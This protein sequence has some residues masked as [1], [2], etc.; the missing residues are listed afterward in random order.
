[1]LQK[2]KRLQIAR[3]PLDIALPQGATKIAI[4]GSKNLIA[5]ASVI[6]NTVNE[7]DDKTTT[8]IVTSPATGKPV[9]VT[10]ET[11]AIPE[12]MDIVIEE[13]TGIHETETYGI[14][15]LLIETQGTCVTLAV[16][17]KF[18]IIARGIDESLILRA[19]LMTD[20]QT[21]DPTR[22]QNAKSPLRWWR[23]HALSRSCEQSLDRY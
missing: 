10:H 22:A 13:N 11:N 8:T 2:Q 21:L 17:E 18:V 14:R 20:D 16:Y 3:R 5:S 9:N 1:L 12:T 6:E 4:R 15:A 7:I 19:D 23:R